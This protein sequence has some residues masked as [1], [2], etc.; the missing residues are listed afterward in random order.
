MMEIADKYM[1]RALQLA[2]NGELDASPN[3]M[4]GAVIVNSS[5][6]IIGE[7]WHR[8]CGEGHAEVNAIASVKDKSS[9]TDATMYVTL[10]PCSHYGKTP[11][12]AELI[13]KTGI[14]RVVIGTLDPF[15]KVSGR[16][17]R[18]LRE[19]GVEVVTGV[20]EKECRELNHKFITAHTL[21][22]P[23]ITLKWAQSA[24]G[25]IDGK[26]STKIT[27]ALVHKLRALNDGILVGSGTVLADNPSLDTRNFAGKSPVKIVLDRRHRVSSDMKCRKDDGARFILLDNYRSLE[28]AMSQLYEKGITSVLVEGGAQVLQSFINDCLW[29]EVRVEIGAKAID[30]KV[31]AP[32]LVGRLNVSDS[33]IV[34][35]TRIITIKKS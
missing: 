17:V 27:S 9:L 12:C 18:R 10:E 14:S 33:I 8:R 20:L 3:P 13:V 26:I 2:R 29:D 25:Y 24:N 11:P 28:G 15:E 34:G 35:G 30:G 31:S 21:H 32:N 22:R 16:G 7:G 19:A 1:R 4:V 5:G 23:Y 6:Q